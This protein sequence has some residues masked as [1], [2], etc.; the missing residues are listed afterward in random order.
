MTGAREGIMETP[1][2]WL[3]EDRAGLRLTADNN[4]D[5]V[6]VG[7]A[8][9]RV[10]AAAGVLLAAL[11]LRRRGVWGWAAVAG[12]VALVKRAIT[13]HCALYARLGVTSEGNRLHAD[14]PSVDPESAIEVRRSVRVDRSP[15]ACYGVW[16]DFSRLPQFVDYLE[17]VDVLDET[18]SRWYAKGPAGVTVEWDA[19]VVRAVEPER[20]AW[21]SVD[22]A[23][24]PNRGVVEFRPADGGA[25]TDVHVQLEWD[26]PG[27]RATRALATAFRRD[28]GRELEHALD[29]FRRVLE[30]GAAV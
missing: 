7:R 2:R 6:N 29:R 22:P 11:G 20:I 27:G 24:V 21:Q 13:G 3:R 12:G 8:E 10:S 17:R 9:R 16:R 19:E 14:D 23:D 5:G 30:A 28:P 4:G 15:A 1:G 18:R 25:A 26:P